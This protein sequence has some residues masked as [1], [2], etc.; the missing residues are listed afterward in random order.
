[1]AG[2]SFR[3]RVLVNPLRWR[4][5]AA[6]SCLASLLVMAA[7]SSTTATAAASRREGIQVP[8]R[9][10]GDDVA[11]A[12]RYEDGESVPRDYRE[13]RVLYCRAARRG[14]P[15][16][17]FQ[18]GWMYLNGRGVRRNTATAAM[19]FRKAAERGVPQAANLLTLLSGVKPSPPQS[20]SGGWTAIALTRA[21][22]AIRALA[23]GT[24]EHVGISAHLL[25]S[26]MA[27]ESGF[28]PRA[29]SPKSAAGLMQL[30]PETAARFGVRDR[31]D[32]RQNI[33]GGATYLRSL[34]EMFDGNLTL[35][36]AA[37]NAGEERV[38]SHGGVP[39]YRE[40][41]NYV[42]AVRRLCHCGK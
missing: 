19:W 20:C 4:G 18:L 13:A 21:P 31:F 40:T 22:P 12:E 24:A 5:C 30:M 27:V 34:L 9:S 2:M 36:L 33:L 3:W 15:Q 23:Q 14:D 7:V 38:I 16:A 41:I 8:S 42:A 32:P 37:Y 29:L 35:A 26:V 17:F 28:N 1:M 25:L 11:L 6:L 39:P 10:A